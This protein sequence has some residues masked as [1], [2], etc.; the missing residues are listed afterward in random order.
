MAFEWHWRVECS[1]ECIDPL[2]L[3]LWLDC[4]FQ[5]MASL[6]REDCALLATSVHYHQSQQCSMSL[7]SMTISMWAIMLL[8]MSN[9]L[10]LLVDACRCLV[11]ISIAISWSEYNLDFRHSLVTKLH[12]TF[13]LD[14]CRVQ[15]P[16]LWLEI[17]HHTVKRDEIKVE[18]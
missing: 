6:S 18:N 17:V 1:Y 13:V 12:W 10:G 4:H 5:W 3:S 7:I 11:A 2:N 8:L 9:L 14:C 15:N 16:D